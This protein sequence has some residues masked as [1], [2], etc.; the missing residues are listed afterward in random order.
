MASSL[1]ATGRVVDFEHSWPAAPALDL[2]PPEA[3]C[4]RMREGYESSSAALAPG[5]ISSGMLDSASDFLPAPLPRPTPEAG[6]AHAWRRLFVLLFVTLPASAGAVT[7]APDTPSALR[8]GARV[9]VAGGR[10]LAG[11]DVQA[12]E[13]IEALCRATAAAPA[14]GSCAGVT[15]DE[16]RVAN[17][18]V[19]R[20]A[21]D[22]LEVS[23][24][25]Y[26][27]C[28]QAGRCT[29]LPVAQCAYGD[30]TRPS[31]AEWKQ[32]SRAT[33]PVVCVTFAQAEAFCKWAGGRLPTEAEWEWAARGADGRIFPWG[34][35]WRPGAL[36]WGDDGRLDGH[37]LTAPVG[38]YPTGA[39]ASGALDLVGNAWEWARRVE[40]FDLTPQP[41]DRQVIRGGGF[42]AAPH[43][44]RTTKRALY[45]PARPYPNVGFRCVY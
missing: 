35:E 29:P 36:N 38:S 6:R 19:P 7:A 2:L 16:G 15:H 27:A 8:R 32:L 1:P 11:T 23:H 3:A 41:A 24:A 37:V 5:G 31:P 26:A 9:A 25:R 10:F 17:V 39:S 18:T 34:N 13:R 14:L 28:V 12:R 20:L 40:A 4:E 33:H 21:L 42:A 22:Q 44:Q 30:G 43:A 45:A